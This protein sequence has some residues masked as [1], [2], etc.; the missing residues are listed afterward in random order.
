MGI[1][2]DRLSVFLN[3]VGNSGQLPACV[4]QGVVCSFD[5]GLFLLQVRDMKSHH[6]PPAECQDQCASHP[7]IFS[8]ADAVL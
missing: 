3:A 1:A 2:A 7:T 6:H 4:P 8:R 5:L